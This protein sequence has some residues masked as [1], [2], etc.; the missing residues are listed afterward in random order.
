MWFQIILISF[1]NPPPTGVQVARPD[2]AVSPP[3]PELD[4]A[5]M[6]RWQAL[7]MI[8]G[9]EPEL[10]RSVNAAFLFRPTRHLILEA[11]DA[12]I[13]AS[14]ELSRLVVAAEARNMRV[15]SLILI[16]LRAQR[17]WETLASMKTC[18]I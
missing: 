13:L 11:L 7:V 12:G 8:Q 15:S 2:P 4:L 18:R 3:A 6:T 16:I 1:Q 10:L 9:I 14:T 17:D 5:Q